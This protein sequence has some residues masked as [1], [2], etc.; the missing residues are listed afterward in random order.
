MK[1]H[2][3]TFTLD[4]S[5][6]E[7]T[8]D[9][10]PVA[11][12]PKVFDILLYLLT[13]RDRTISK[14]E[15]I[16][17]VWEG[18]IVS[19]AAVTSRINLVRQAVGDN[20]RDQNMI[21]TVSKRGFRFVGDVDV[22]EP[23]APDRSNRELVLKPAGDDQ[24]S[25]LVLPFKDL[26]NEEGQFLAQ[27]LTED[28][29]VALSRHSDVSVISHNTAQ[30]LGEKSALLQTPLA[31]VPVDFL[32]SGTVRVAA[33]TVRI[34]VQLSE[35]ATG[36]TVYSEKFD[37][38]LDDIFALQD[39]IVEALAG[40]L[41]WRVVD[42][43]G[44]KLA[45]EK[46][47]KLTT[48]QHYLKISNAFDQSQDILAYHVDLQNLVRRDPTYGFG[49]AQLAFISTFK[50]FH[51]GRQSEAEVETAVD[52]AR[53][54]LK[55]A[56]QNER[57][58]AKAAM[59]FQFAGQFS[60]AIKLSSQAILLN[61]NSTDCT[62]F[63]ASVLAAS[64]RAEEALELHKKTQS[65]DPL[66]PEAH[67]EG[68]VEALFLLGKYQ[69][70]LEI[71]D[72]WREPGRHIVAYTGAFAAMAGDEKRAKTSIEAFENS[73][74]DG[75]SNETLVSSILRYHSR[76]EDRER[77]LEGFRR[78]GLTGLDSIKTVSPERRF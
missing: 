55:L 63:H 65:L 33:N 21:Q 2:F 57:A 7:L 6:P 18:R 73:R 28:L 24:A 27:G 53:Q 11:V 1:A 47:P 10:V 51:I 56:P 34:T 19:D 39:E 42:A 32:V 50:V 59:V 15:L 16:D 71:I 31:E 68:M 30:R 12:E 13:H 60:V 54:A 72:Q 61:P 67:Y 70:A 78:S 9:G 26:S 75:F 74:P 48:Y 46:P 49:H 36:I 17:Q 41:P 20:G 77:W 38:E 37:R 44:R 23:P 66:F 52:H 25:V 58:L 4:A 64:G 69:D 35:R 3:G 76:I 29:I 14:D 45:R 22:A 62:H 5:V 43:V 40:C 8:K